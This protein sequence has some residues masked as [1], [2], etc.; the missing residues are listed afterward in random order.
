MLAGSSVSVRTVPARSPWQGC[1]LATYSAVARARICAR[2]PI[3]ASL[4][5]APA[6]PDGF[7][8]LTVTVPSGLRVTAN[9]GELVDAPSSNAAA[10]AIAARPTVEPASS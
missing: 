1:S 9:A 7:I 10:V 3:A 6:I 2:T 8:R 4:S 5:F